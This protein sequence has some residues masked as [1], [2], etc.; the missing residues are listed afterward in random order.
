MTQAPGWTN[1]K[2]AAIWCFLAGVFMILM[3]FIRAAFGMAIR[4]ELGATVEGTFLIVYSVI[5]LVIAFY[6]VM[7]GVIAARHGKNL[8]KANS[9]R[10]LATISLVIGVGLVVFETIMLGFSILAIIML[11]DLIRSY[12]YLRGAT[13][14]R[15]TNP[16]TLDN[17]VYDRL[18]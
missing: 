17:N 10:T 14:N 4:D 13:R 11:F 1:L 3:S 2:I 8:A 7:M 18:T 9:L 5:T 15:E 6:Y 12:L 16:N